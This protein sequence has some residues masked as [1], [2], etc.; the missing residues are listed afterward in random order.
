MTTAMASHGHGAAEA[1]IGDARFFFRAKGP[2]E[3]F[4]ARMR[5]WEAG[6]GRY[7]FEG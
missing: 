4:I 5:G 6:F 1:G 3:L 2:L 7:F